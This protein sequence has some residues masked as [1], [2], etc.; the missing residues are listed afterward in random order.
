MQKKIRVGKIGGRERG[1]KAAGV[2]LINGLYS[3]RW[4]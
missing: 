2:G 1:Q 4:F 3:C